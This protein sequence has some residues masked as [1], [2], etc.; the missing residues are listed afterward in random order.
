MS[1]TVESQFSDE[2][3]RLMTGHRLGKPLHVYRMR[4]GYILFNRVSSL[5]VFILC[6]VFV[7][8]LIS[9]I[10]QFIERSGVFYL[11]AY[12]GGLSF[13]LPGGCYLFIGLR[14]EE[15]SRRLIIGE[16]GLLEIR[17][18]I[19]NNRIEVV[20]WK[21]IRAIRKAFIAP[22]YLIKR[23]RGEPFLL[24]PYVFQNGDELVSLIREHEAEWDS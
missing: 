21:D 1:Q 14:H 7:W 17:K 3:R 5:I 10:V 13:L 16:D 11:L 18:M 4:Q 12:F 24:T 22:E 8:M 2:D 9:V 19:R 23:R 20:H 15:Q 6:I